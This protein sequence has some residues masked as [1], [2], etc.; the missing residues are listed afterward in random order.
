VGT[1]EEISKKMDAI[2]AGMT[3]DRYIEMRVQEALGEEKGF[4]LLVMGRPEGPGCYCYVNNLLRDMIGRITRSY[5]FVV[6]DNAA[7]MEHISRRTM[8]EIDRL[9]LVSDY[10]V[11]GIRSAKRIYDL[12]KELAIKIKEAFLVV[13]KATGP[14]EAL[15]AELDS[16]GLK[17]AGAIPYD[18]TLA[19]LAL[20]GRP[21]FEFGDDK[22]KRSVEAI[23][24]VIS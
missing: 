4:D 19:E 24:K 21:I 10:S 5:D 14:V 23:M 2:P 12:A 8:R 16:A 11:F 20:S 9:I 15:K 17:V 22:M 7:G 18:E 1:I 3:K 13:N 6:V